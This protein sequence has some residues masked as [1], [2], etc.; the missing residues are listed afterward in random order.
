MFF[1]VILALP[2]AYLASVVT[3]LLTKPG[4]RVASML[5]VFSVTA[6]IVGSWFGVLAIRAIWPG[7]DVYDQTGNNLLATL[8]GGP[9]LGLLV[10]ALVWRLTNGRRHRAR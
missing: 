4:W 2:M 7:N 5:I 10:I 9:I 8:T 3:L 6:V 1:L